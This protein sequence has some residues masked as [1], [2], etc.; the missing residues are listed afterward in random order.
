MAKETVAVSGLWL[1]RMGD[2]VEVLVEIDGVW[3][4]AITEPLDANFSHIAE[5]GGLRLAPVDL[6]AAEVPSPEKRP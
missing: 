5:T 3:R 2:D 6:L 1:R 4:L